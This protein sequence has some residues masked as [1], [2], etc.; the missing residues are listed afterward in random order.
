M[1]WRT[2]CWCW[3]WWSNQ[4]RQYWGETSCS[5]ERWWWSG[6]TLSWPP[7]Q[8]LAPL[9]NLQWTRLLLFNLEFGTIC[10]SQEELG[11]IKILKKHAN[12]P[13]PVALIQSLSKIIPWNFRLIFW[14]WCLKNATM[15]GQ[16]KTLSI[17]CRLLHQTAWK[18]WIIYSFSSRRLSE[19]RMMNIFKVSKT[20][21]AGK[22]LLQWLVEY[23]ADVHIKILLDAG[24]S[25]FQ[26]FTT[27]ED[28]ITIVCIF[29]C[30]EY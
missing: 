19:L 3:W 29:R 12:V 4:Q 13:I 24:Y 22:T 11:K 26:I 27:K 21:I 7:Q 15:M 10:L 30:T 8:S 5:C 20:D 14:A 28:K 2:Y 16:A 1:K 23:D 18:R 6:W 9:F 25:T 17:L